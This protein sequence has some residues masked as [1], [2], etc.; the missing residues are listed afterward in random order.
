MKQLI[1]EDSKCPYVSFR[2]INIVNESFRRHINWGSNIDIFKVGFC[3]LGESEI[4]N[5]GN[6]IMQEYVSY[7]DIS[8]DNMIL[9]Q[10]LQAFEYIENI[11]LS[12]SLSKMLLF[13]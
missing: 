13:S 2:A 11:R 8:M 3:K 6:S 5:F 4:S 7:F 12:L 9:C 10:I 1:D